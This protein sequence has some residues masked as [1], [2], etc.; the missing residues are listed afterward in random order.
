MAD[1]DSQS[2]DSPDMSSSTIIPELTTKM[3]EVLSKTSISNQTADIATVPIGIKL[4]GT[5]HALWSQVVEMY[6]S[7]KDK[8]GHINGDISQSGFTD[9][10]FRKWRTDDAIVKSWLINSMESSL[11]GNFIRFPTAKIR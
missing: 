10:S 9:P 2:S 6:I 8:L 1:N 3:A 4:D 11:I 5:N 7:G